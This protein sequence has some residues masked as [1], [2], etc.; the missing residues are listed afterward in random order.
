H[1]LQRHPRHP[2]GARH[3]RRDGRQEGPALSQPPHGARGPPVRLGHGRRPADGG[4]RARLRLQGHH[5]DAP[6]ARRPR[7]PHRLLRRPLDAAL[8]HG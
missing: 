1:H 7:A 3:D 6:Q 8:L 5:D 2:A 4:G